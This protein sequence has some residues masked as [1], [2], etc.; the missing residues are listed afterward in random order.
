MK[1]RLL[2]LCMLVI[3]CTCGFAQTIE[4]QQRFEDGDLRITSAEKLFSGCKM[5]MCS[6]ES[7]DG[8]YKIYG[9]ELDMTDRVRFVQ[10]GD[11]FTIFL[12]GEESISL[13]NMYET[14]A[15]VTTE[16][17]VQTHDR[18]HTD[19]VMTYDPWFDIISASPITRMTTEHVPV[20]TSTSYANLYYVLTSEQIERI[21]NGK[22]ERVTIV[23]ANKTIE[24]K[25]RK[26][27][28]TMAELFPLIKFKK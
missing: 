25:A 1:S 14:R 13:A 23:A 26:L 3:V 5:R 27:S 22:V 8:K 7:D 15:D 2:I 11:L 19:F 18:M 12:E 24:K 9:I 17:H 10:E 20:T 16:Q 4:R 28:E 6:Y 21:I